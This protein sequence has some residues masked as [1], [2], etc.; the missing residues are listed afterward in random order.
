MA[1]AIVVTHWRPFLLENK[2]IVWTDQKS[3]CH[4]LEQEIV[5]PA[6]QCWIPKLFMVEDKAGKTNRAADALSCREHTKLHL[7]ALSHHPRRMD[8]VDIDIAV[9]GSYTA[10]HPL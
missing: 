8:I 2:F 4:L 7:S 9:W 5:T 1:L 10:T 6:Q 3:L